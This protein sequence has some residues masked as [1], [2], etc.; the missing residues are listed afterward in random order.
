MIW[1]RKRFVRISSP[2]CF[3]P[4]TIPKIYILGIVMS[5]I[6]KSYEQIADI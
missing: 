1:Q 5:I 2:H 3:T 6:K 4:T